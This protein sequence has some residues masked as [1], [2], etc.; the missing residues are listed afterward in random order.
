MREKG[1]RE[2]RLITAF[3]LLGLSFVNGGQQ[4][5]RPE[6]KLET[7]TR[8][9]ILRG[10]VISTRIC[11]VD[12]VIISMHDFFFFSLLTSVRL[13]NDQTQFPVALYLGIAFLHARSLASLPQIHHRAHFGS[14]M[15]FTAPLTTFRH[16][17]DLFFLNLLQ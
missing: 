17:E 6:E 11:L 2:R 16:S 1:E 15:W 7:T 5:Q 4:Q 10:G 12:R 8:E 9:A 14:K 3:V 13:T